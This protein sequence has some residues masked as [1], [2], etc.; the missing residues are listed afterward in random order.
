MNCNLLTMKT[1]H[2][3]HISS[4]F[5]TASYGEIDG[6]KLFRC[7]SVSQLMHAFSKLSVFP[8]ILSTEASVNTFL[9]SRYSTGV[10]I[11][12]IIDTGA[13]ARSTAGQD[14]FY[15]LQQIQDIKARQVKSRRG[16]DPIRAPHHSE[17]R[18][19][20]THWQDYLSCGPS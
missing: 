11:G 9:S 12:I 20:D 14:Q 16:Q 7:S 19:S 15:A 2:R 1:H 10:F 4:V 5:T 13:A 6:E 3:N 18:Y 17:L 8:K